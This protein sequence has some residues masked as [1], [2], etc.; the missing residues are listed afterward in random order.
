MQFA[1]TDERVARVATEEDFASVSRDIAQRTLNRASQHPA[2][3]TGAHELSVA[4]ATCAQ[5]WAR[6]QLTR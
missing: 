6:V 5:E 4:L 3:R 1:T 2:V